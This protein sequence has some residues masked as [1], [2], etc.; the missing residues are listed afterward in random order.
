MKSE[1][2]RGSDPPEMGGIFKSD[3]GFATLDLSTGKHLFSV[4]FVRRAKP[5]EKSTCCAAPLVFFA[6]P[7]VCF[8]LFPIKKKI[9]DRGAFLS[10]SLIG[11][12]DCV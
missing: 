2:A 5:M 12:S 7:L 1:S 10:V 6:F 9:V 4:K 8:C 3:S 11:P